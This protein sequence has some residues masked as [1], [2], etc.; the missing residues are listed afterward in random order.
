MRYAL[1]AMR[2]APHTMPTRGQREA[3]SVQ[4][5]L[6]AD[7]VLI[8]FAFWL[9]SVVRDPLFDVVSAVVLRFFGHPMFKDPIPGL[10]QILWLLY[11]F[12]PCTPL[13]L[14]RFGFYEN[15]L[16]RNFVKSLSRVLKGYAVMLLV[17]LLFSVFFKLPTSSRLTLA[18][19][20]P[21]SMVFVLLRDGVVA[22]YSKRRAARGIG[23]EN[24]A[25]AGSPEDVR[26]LREKLPGEVTALWNVV[27]EFDL[28]SG[29]EDDFRR[30]LNEQAVGRVIFAAGHA[31]FEAV[32]RAI[33]ICELQGIEAWVAT[34]FIRTQI[35]RPTFDSLG[36]QPMLV[37]RSTPDL[38]WELFAKGVI[39]WIGA[40]VLL[41]ATLPIWVVAMV[42]IK[43]QSPGPVFYRQMRTGRYG[44][45]FRLIKFRTMCVDA[46]EKLEELKK[47]Y[48]NEMSEPMF[49]LENDPRVFPFGRFMR[50]FSIDELPQVLN[51][52]RGEMSLVGPR[53]MTLYELE[54][55]DN[56]AHRRKL[57]MKP[58]IT[59]LW[60]ISGRNEITD[61]DEWVR[62]DLEYIDNW[63]L[64]LDLK[65][66]LM[67]LPAVLF[68]K[69]AK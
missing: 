68:G 30:M 42:V 58:G 35:A 1:C 21:L 31:E 24:V 5:M 16:Q 26:D 44:R 11:I 28:V 12:V 49:K 64:W 43:L 37:L 29:G 51:V 66:L 50:R 62:L 36:G 57:S 55:I 3:F 56:L 22:H 13:V 46:E 45:P 19:A 38:S 8:W 67:T 4:L 54:L 59:C 34:G 20:I 6:L 61:F 2:F 39:D 23:L 41:V 9:A 7:A 10:S 63:S 32:A 27:G 17:V 48:G 47:N 15:P 25:F 69:G 18:T 33:E 53:P 52:L 14:E 40:L 65:I 60:Q